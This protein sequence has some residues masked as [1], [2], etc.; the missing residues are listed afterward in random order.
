MALVIKY[1]LRAHLKS[2]SVAK[3]AT[4][5]LRACCVL[6]FP[7]LSRW[8]DPPPFPVHLTTPASSWFL[9][10]HDSSLLFSPLLSLIQHQFTHSASPLCFT[11][12]VS[13][14]ESL[15]DPVTTV[16]ADVSGEANHRSLAS[17]QMAAFEQVFTWGGGSC[18]HGTN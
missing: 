16:L 12:K 10:P 8:S 4:Q 5:F 3:F 14:G 15:T 18:L 6:V 17:F 9:P 7:S 13:K 1:H 11:V 2:S